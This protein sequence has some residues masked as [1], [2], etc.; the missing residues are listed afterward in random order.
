MTCQEICDILK[1]D[2]FD[3]EIGQHKD[4]LIKRHLAQ[5]PTCQAFEKILQAQ[6]AMFQQAKSQTPPDR[7][8]KNI[9][10]C[11]AEEQNA[12]E[13]SVMTRFSRWVQE[14]F[15]APRPTFA[16]G[17]TF[18]VV[19]FL[20]VFTVGMTIHKEQAAREESLTRLTTDSLNFE[21]LDILSDFGTNIEKFLL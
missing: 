3:G 4:E 18:A 15:F 19:L 10:R 11:I 2:F 21:N 6:R 7:L 17:S 12:K 5:C 14:S 9:E 20:V 16:L 1:A 8:W 13:S